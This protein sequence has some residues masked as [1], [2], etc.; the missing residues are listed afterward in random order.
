L[1][2]AVHIQKIENYRKSDQ[3][4]MG[5]SMPYRSPNGWNPLWC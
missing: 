2:L 5:F 1:A 4:A 3:E